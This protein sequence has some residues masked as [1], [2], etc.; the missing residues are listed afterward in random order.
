MYKFKRAEE[1]YGLTKYKINY[2]YD[3]EFEFL[4]PET[5]KKIIEFI[6]HQYVSRWGKTMRI[7]EID[8]CPEF[9]LPATKSFRVDGA[10]ITYAEVKE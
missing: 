7:Q 9:N 6:E 10:I 2:F 5:E 3:A 8:A 1:H 4:T